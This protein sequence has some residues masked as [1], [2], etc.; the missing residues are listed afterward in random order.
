[1]P[2]PS[3]RRKDMSCVAKRSRRSVV[4]VELGGGVAGLLADDGEVSLVEVVRRH[5][6][7]PVAHGLHA[8]LAAH[9]GD[10]GGAELV[11]P[12]RQG[13]EVDV[14]VQA[15]PRRARL[16]H[17][18]LLLRALGRRELDLAVQPPRPEQRRVQVVGAVRRHDHPH[19]GG[20]VEAVHLG[21][22]LNQHALHV[23]P[24]TAVVVVAALP[25]RRD[26]VHL[27]DE[28]DGR[29]HVPGEPEQVAHHPRPVVPRELGGVHAE[30]RR[31]GLPRD[32]LGEHG[33]PG[34]QRAVQE[35]AARRV[36]A[37]GGEELRVRQR[38]LHG[39]AH[40]PLLRLAPADVVVG[41]AR[42]VGVRDE[43]PR[44]RA[45]GDVGGG[46]AD[47]RERPAVQRDVRRGLEEAAVERAGDADAHLPLASVAQRHDGVVLV[48]DL[49]ELG[50]DEG[51]DR[52]QPP[53]EL[54]AE[55]H[56]LFQHV[57]LEQRV[58]PLLIQQAEL[59]LQRLQLLAQLASLLVV[60]VE[61][62]ELVVL[63]LQVQQLELLF[64]GSL[65]VAGAVDVVLPL[66]H[67]GRTRPRWSE[68][69]HGRRPWLRICDVVLVSK[70]ACNASKRW[71]VN[72]RRRASTNPSRRLGFR[73]IHVRLGFRL[74]HANYF[75]SPL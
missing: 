18:P 3:E 66:L 6:A 67:A 72:Y 43:E 12:R 9:G 14:A 28:D 23:A 59:P 73:L 15:H 7:P 51:G 22:Q 13:V 68:R 55:A 4:E 1:M 29:R 45:G 40:L 56:R 37:G 27:V 30:E 11:A 75:F 71:R 31:R 34:A 32:G 25:R 60:G 8:G 33:L 58:V 63:L 50:D 64:R 38:Q 44:G 57:N 21:E 69:H 65:G 54:L 61:E 47:E 42:L 39:L 46:H 53:D 24:G 36:D 41:D 48:D 10:L 62:D 5:G 52:R 26:R 17:Q 49:V 16:Q 74:I 2:F 19:V 70:N 35:H 20:L